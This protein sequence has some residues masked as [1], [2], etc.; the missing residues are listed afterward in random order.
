MPNPKKKRKVESPELESVDVPR[1]TCVLHVVG[2]DHGQFTTFKNV[3]GN[4]TEKLA[5]LHTVRDQR[6]AEPAGSVH[7]MDIVC[8]LI[9]ESLEDDDL[10]SYGYHRQCY[11]RFNANLD[12]LTGFEP[13]TASCSSRHHSPR[14]LPSTADVGTGS[15]GLFPPECIF[16]EK[17]ER[18]VHDKTERP[19]KF[20]SWKH[21]GSAW[22]H[23]GP[24]ALA[25]GRMRLHRM[26]QD[27]D[28][29]AVEAQCHLNCRDN[30]RNEY[31]ND[32]R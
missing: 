3:R 18:K 28:L 11:Q 7:R 17:L 1:E 16:C 20:A 22:Q 32:N 24:Q 31:Q 8:G 15:L 9:P 30:F 19:V 4:S 25:L 13:S 12:R 6:L 27:T 21:K 26:V 29:H 10:E 2:I 23:I 5:Q 14:K